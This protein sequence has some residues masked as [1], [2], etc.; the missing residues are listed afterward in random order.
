MQFA[1]QAGMEV[2]FDARI[3]QGRSSSR[4]NGTFT[5][6]QALDILLS[7][8]GLTYRYTDSN[9]VTLERIA[10]QENEN[11]VILAPITVRGERV[12]RTLFETASSAV[13][14]GG[15]ELDRA[16]SENS[17]EDVLENIPNVVTF[18][19]SN[20]APVIR[21]QQT[22]GP[23]SG[24]ASFF[25][26]TLPRATQTVDGRAISYSEYVYGDSSVWDVET[27]EV[28]RGPQTTSQGANSIAGG[29]YV[30]TKDPS[31]DFET[32]LQGEAGSFDSFQT[33]GVLNTPLIE[34]EL[35]A[36]VAFD[37]RTRDTF[38]DYATPGQSLIDESL[39][40]DQLN[41][42]AKL[43]WEPEAVPELSTK[44]T[45]TRTDT[46]APQTEL[47]DE[48]FEDLQRT[49]NPNP[50]AFTTRSDSLIHD[51]EYLLPG[52]TTLKN[53][54]YWS[55]FEADRL[56]AD[57]NQGRTSI[58]GD[59]FS[60]ET[61]VNLSLFDSRLTGV[62]GL[63]MRRVQDE[64]ISQFNFTITDLDDVKT[65]L[66][67]FSELTYFVTDSFD[68]TAGLR[69]QRDRQ[70]RDGSV[71]AVPGVNAGLPLDYDETFDDLLP[72]FAVGYDV[73]DD[74][75]IGAVIS[76]GFNPGGINF[77]FASFFGGQ[78]DPFF[79]FDEETLWN[80]EVFARANLLDDRLVLSANA[81]Y[82]DIENAQRATTTLLPNGF[83]DT[84]V[85][86][87]EEARSM[88]LEASATF[89]VV[90]AFSLYGSAGL[91]STEFKEFSASAVNLE[92]NEFRGAPSFT[93]TLGFNWE[94]IANLNLGASVRYNSGY[95]SDD[96]NTAEREVDAFAIFDFKLAY[97]PMENVR[98]FG[99]VNNLFDEVT[100]VN[101]LATGGGR[102]ATTTA[103]RE[104]GI[105]ARFAF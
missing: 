23:L 67:V 97:E 82:S 14:V 68:V 58:E 100:P 72:K 41:A 3:A 52:E 104:F 51:I 36:R 35:A 46:S 89:Q 13:A 86:N 78:P 62:G 18:G 65:S 34:D 16:P 84:V 21:G 32:I 66:G 1:E 6:E 61:L 83:I 42:R 103:P 56:V 96:A 53:K 48:P 94:A 50:P 105:G 15:R 43:L 12:E 85:V 40:I 20:E 5:K 73:T 76:K 54:F 79:E 98:L 47:V 39:S 95:Y 55:A 80:Y 33:S 22:G 60:N 37:Y 74:I 101:I 17:V 8:T 93:G 99:Y 63:L 59:D 38:I 45:Y 10:V 90:E 91:L 31:F 71:F 57:V 92:G 27:I 102:V 24:G 69:Y 87:A 88:G 44:L 28:F 64:T 70:R 26:G 77:S 9:T 75:R 81:F 29:I 25:S 19:G 4:V 11:P 49:T 7:G 2:L 30:Q